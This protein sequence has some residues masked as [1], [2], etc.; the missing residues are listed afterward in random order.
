[1]NRRDY[2]RTRHVII[3]FALAMDIA[4]LA[5]SPS[6]NIKFLLTCFGGAIMFL[7]YLERCRN[8]KWPIWVKSGGIG[9]LLFFRFVGPFY[10]PSKCAHCGSPDFETPPSEE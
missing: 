8:C 4:I 1:M 9:A 5:I 3:I 7:F 2:V 6:E 10:I